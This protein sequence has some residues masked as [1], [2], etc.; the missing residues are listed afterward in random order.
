MFFLYSILLTIGFILFLP[1]V[2]L[3]RG[4]YAAGFWQRLGRLP[5]LETG[6]G[7]KIVW[8][9]CVSVGETNAARPLVKEILE[10]FPEYKIVVS[11]TTKTGQELAKQVFKDQAA[12]VFYF[13]FDWKF[14]V[15]RALRHI[16]PSVVLLM[17]TEL[18]F[19]FLRQA[20][21]SGARIAIVNGR[22]S[23]KSFSRYSYIKKAM[24]RVLHYIDLALMQGRADAKRLIELGIRSSKVKI[25]G[26]VKFDQTYEENEL[27]EYFRARFAI[28]G[29]RRIRDEHVRISKGQ[30]ISAAPFKRQSE[31]RRRY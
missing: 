30:K 8:L 20:N 5:D 16:K 3:R 9:H 4:K 15:R 31:H 29:A 18:W 28:S 7:R 6:D 13:P 23:E 17:E 25:T 1:L 10:N 22:L 24:R 26:N 27:T 19:N 14:T 11:T 2:V 21:K 12:L